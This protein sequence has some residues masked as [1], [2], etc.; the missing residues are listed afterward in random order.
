MLLQ[1][2]GH[3]LLRIVPK[4]VST[5]T[6]NIQLEVSSD[7]N[8][9]RPDVRPFDRRNYDAMGGHHKD[10][11]ETPQKVSIFFHSDDE[12]GIENAR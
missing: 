6:D 12:E 2:G 3:G 1:K 5:A 8:E 10:G 11:D 7:L 4:W 9:R